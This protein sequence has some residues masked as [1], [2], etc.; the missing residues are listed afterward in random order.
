MEKSE[1]LTFHIGDFPVVFDVPVMIATTVAFLIVLILAFLAS[2]KLTMVPTGL[3][4]F[5]EMIIDFTSNIV[6]TNMDEKTASRFYGFA[7]TLFVYIVVANELGLMFNVIT[8]EGN[9]QNAYTWWKSP[10]ADINAVFSLAIAIT[11]F[12]H[13]LGIWKSP[14]HYLKEYF[15]P[16]WWMFP[17]HIIDE[18][19]KPLTHG[20][21][22]WANIFAGEVLVIVLLQLNWLFAGAPL[23]VWIGYS[24]FVGVVQAYVF[25]ILAFIYI[26]QKITTHE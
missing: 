1:K 3:Q 20:M 14:K 22:L 19:A 26:S 15:Q 16:Y 8:S 21:R 2:R 24:L 18:I 9:H 25:T 10:T 7:F 23:M 17:L 11:L 12:A 13:L 4:N 6:R 5:I